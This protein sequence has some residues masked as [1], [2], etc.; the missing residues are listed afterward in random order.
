MPTSPNLVLTDEFSAALEHL[1]A[2]HHMFLTGKAGTGKSTLIRH[3]M[4]ATDRNVVV[5]APTGIAALN[6]DGYTIHRLFSFPP[7]VTAEDVQDPTYRPGRFAKAIKALDTLIVDEASM[8]RADLFDALGA[9]LER[10]GPRPGEP[11][12]GVQVVLVGDLYQLP[13]VV[14]EDEATFFGTRYATPYFFSADRFDVDTFARAQLTR[15][16]RQAGDAQLTGI[17]NAIREGTID[18]EARALLNRRTRPDFRADDGEFWLTLTT[19]NRIA[20]ARNR[21][22]LEQ[23]PGETLEWRGSLTGEV[24]RGD[25]PTDEVLTVKVGAQVMLLVNDPG[26]AFVNGT[27]GTITAVEH[28]SDGTPRVSIHTRDGNDVEVG[29]HVWETTRPVVD[30]GRIV[31]EVIGTFTQLPFRLAWAITIHKSQGQTVDRLV[32]DLSGGTFAYGQLYVALSRCTSMEGLVLQRDVLPR[33][34]KTDQRIRRFLSDGVAPPSAP[35]A[36][37]GVC[38]AGHVGRM[39]RPRPVELAV[40]TDDGRELTTLVNPESDLYDSRQE[41]GITAAD[42]LPAPR[43]A[44]A[45]PALLA[46]LEGAVPVGV[47]VDEHLGYLDFEL[48]RCGVVA[49]MPLG[50]ELP[51]ADLLPDE[52]RALAAPTALERARATAAIDARLRPANLHASTFPPPDRAGYLLPRGATV[53]EARISTN[54]T[55]DEADELRALVAS[56]APGAADRP[57]PA[58]VLTPGA[59][60]C[61]TGSVLD[62]DGRPIGRDEMERLAVARGLAVASNVSRTRCDV[63]VCAEE[64]SQSGKARK[65]REFGKPILLADDFLAWAAQA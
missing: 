32:V 43:L 12:G 23:L 55:A 17:L 33:D 24:D 62:A 59:R 3:F 46:E 54:A 40:V 7:G 63:L 29:P 64:G 20:S 1:H 58:A 49:P 37:L 56:R 5:V 47:A 21:R 15:V 18:E 36:H 10:F 11:F 57:D 19:T 22:A 44:E 31:Q 9:A 52:R 53:D 38:W 4:A 41:Y 16:F 42:V 25:L 28:D 27:L 60:V 50:L 51:S 48:K 14:R 13:A 45:W 2:G 65:A 6:V 61:F 35:R 39:T 30:G 34:L 26:D 8:V